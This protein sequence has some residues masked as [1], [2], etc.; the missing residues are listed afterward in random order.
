M[1]PPPSRPRAILFDWDNTLVDTWESLR[2]AINA[3]LVAFGH[4]PWTLAETR[5]RVRR[6][7]RDTFPIM[8]GDRWQEAR[9]IFY[10]TFEAEH[11]ATVAELPGAGAALAELA[12][13]VPLGVVSNKQGVL[14]R[15]EADRLGWT[16]HFRSLVGAT[17]A[18]RDKP[19]RAPVDLALQI[20]SQTSGKI[21]VSAVWFVG[22]TGLDMQAAHAA[23]CVPVL[24]GRG[25]G[26]EE[27]L[28]LHPPRFNVQNMDH[29]REIWRGL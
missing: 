27:A 5:L 2:V 26:D 4:A 11:L 9:A 1:T 12:A 13:A 28:A 3:A 22:D 8:F 24:F 16:G 6:S 20:M 14:L 15:R 19:D 18:V 7:L 25:E 10:K 29:L 17:D 23:G 21:D